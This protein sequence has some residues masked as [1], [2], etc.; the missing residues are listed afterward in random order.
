MPPARWLTGFSVTE[1]DLTGNILIIGIGNTLRRDDGAGWL[2]AEALTAHL[3]AAGLSI[4]LELHHQLTPDLAL[5]AA[6]L[7]PAAI[8]FVDASIAVDEPTLTSLHLDESASAA[9][10]GLT[11]A[12]LLTLMRRL[13]AVDAQGWLV[14]TPAEDFGHGAGLSAKAQ[15]GLDSTATVASLLLSRTIASPR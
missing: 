1:Y 3:R 7:Q 9:S 11:P 10:H 4:H 2:F 6:E 13:Y 15:R 12:A 5:D 8:I 14:Q